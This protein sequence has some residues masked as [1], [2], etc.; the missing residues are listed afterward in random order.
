MANYEPI[1]KV[2]KRMMSWNDEN[3]PALPAAP[4]AP[5]EPLR[6]YMIQDHRGKCYFCATSKA[7]V[8]RTDS[9][10]YPC[11][12]NCAKSNGIHEGSLIYETKEA[13]EWVGLGRFEGL[14]PDPRSIQEQL[15]DLGKRFKFLSRGYT[16]G[17]DI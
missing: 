4:V 5:V 1:Y 10:D 8:L 15:E 9:G 11:C 12:I 6:P 7:L 17:S 16:I 2:P 13:S 14:N 3:I